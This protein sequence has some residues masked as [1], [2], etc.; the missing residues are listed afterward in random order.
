MISNLILFLLFI[1]ISICILRLLYNNDELYINTNIS[2]D[3]TTVIQQAHNSKLFKSQQLTPIGVVDHNNDN[4]LEYDICKKTHKNIN[5]AACNLSINN[6]NDINKVDC[7]KHIKCELYSK[8][9]GNETLF[10][11]VKFYAGVPCV[12]GK[13]GWSS[14]KKECDGKCVEFGVTGGFY[15]FPKEYASI[16]DYPVRTIFQKQS[17]RPG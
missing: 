12:N 7:D 4:P 5:D 2:G 14:C 16:K 17:F 8:N 3:D 1:V 11:D 15:C 10:S 13:D 6:D 9:Y